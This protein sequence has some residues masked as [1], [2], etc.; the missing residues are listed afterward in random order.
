MQKLHMQSAMLEELPEAAAGLHC[1]HGRKHAQSHKTLVDGTA[2]TWGD[3][4]PLPKVCSGSVSSLLSREGKTI[5]S[6]PDAAGSNSP[7]ND[8][9]ILR[10]G[11][12][13]LFLQC[14]HN[15]H[16][17]RF[18]ENPSFQLERESSTKTGNSRLKLSSWLTTL[19]MTPPSSMVVRLFEADWV[20]VAHPLIPSSP[21]PTRERCYLN[22][23]HD[24]LSLTLM[25]GQLVK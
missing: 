2:E 15:W 5:T 12:W 17:G 18:T 21:L 3:P 19:T 23:Q 9:L 10:V 20:S 1:A 14:P 24:E 13:K 7:S 16:P 22:S 8:D 11:T 4:W 25:R 6:T